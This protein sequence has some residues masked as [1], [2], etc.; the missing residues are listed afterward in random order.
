MAELP[1]GG[2]ETLIRTTFR[3]AVRAPFGGACYTVPSPVM[4]PLHPEEL[5]L[6]DHES[7]LRFARWLGVEVPNAEASRLPK[8]RVVA[9]ITRT[10]RGRKT[11]RAA[12][13]L[14]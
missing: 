6:S 12:G 7:L 3:A 11:P 10:L 14:R 5:A 2:S 1:Y 9:E 13:A 8:K 4:P